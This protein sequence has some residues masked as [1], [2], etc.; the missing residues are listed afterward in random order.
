M[1]TNHEVSCT[2]RKMPIFPK[3]VTLEIII[4]TES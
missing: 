3:K 2:K 4:A 1:N